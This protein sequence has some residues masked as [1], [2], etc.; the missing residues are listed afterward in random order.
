MAVANTEVKY[1]RSTD[2][3]APMFSGGAGK[4]I[5]VLDVL[6]AGYGQV[7]LDSLVVA[8]D[9]ATGTLSTG[10]GFVM[11]G[12]TVGPVILIAGATPSSLNG[13]WRIAT[14]PGS[15]TFTFAT[16]GIS[17][18]TA[19]GT[20]TAKIAPAGRTKVYS[21]TNLA[22][23]QCDDPTGNQFFLYVDDTGT[24]NARFRGYESMTSIS[25]GTNPFPT[26][27]Q[28]SGG[29]YC[30]K[31]NAASTAT[32]PWIIIADPHFTYLFTDPTANASWN[33][34]LAFGDGNSY[35]ADDA[36]AGLILG[37]QT[38]SGDFQ[39]YNLSSTVGSFIARSY[40]QTGTSIYAGR[41]THARMSSLGYASGGVP[42]LP[43]PVD[44]NAHVWPVE[45]Y[46]SAGPGRGFMPGLWCP[47]HNS[48]MS[49]GTIISDIANLPDHVLMLQKTVSYYYA[50]MD[51]SGPWR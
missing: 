38:S 22:A 51:I 31:S 46:E 7:T 35:K 41:A 14:V 20:I 49:Q 47:I 6:I 42:V 30:Y 37:S 23:Y 19:T 33:G 17:D 24:T 16:E 18:Q 29:L 1:Y 34:G 27:A 44:N 32:R 50:A 8:S 39:L 25:S 5:N 40:T 4:L 21:G 45:F 15:T 10:H 12:G 11:V 28:L 2:S 48:G 36:F 43:S 26:D 3:G 9:V 13:E